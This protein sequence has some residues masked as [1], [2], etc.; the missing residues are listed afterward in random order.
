MIFTAWTNGN[1]GFGFKISIID[2]DVYFSKNISPVYIRLPQNEEFLTVECNTDKDSFWNK[3]CKEL[4][5]SDIG[6]WL[7]TNNYYPWPNGNPPKFEVQKV[8]QNT[9]QIIKKIY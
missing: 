8:N 9:Y 4:I 6:I 2:R 5:N 7:K 1:K 3:T